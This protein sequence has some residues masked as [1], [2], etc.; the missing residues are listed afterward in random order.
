[1]IRRTHV[2]IFRAD[3]DHVLIDMV[4]MHVVQ[5][6]VVEIV[7]VIAMPDSGVTASRTVDMRVIG[8][9]RIV[10]FGHAVTP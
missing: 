6:A 8:V 2:R 10:A 9:L 3:F 4:I 5:M 7:Y 1:M